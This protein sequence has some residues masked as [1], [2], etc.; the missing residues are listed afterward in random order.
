M[1]LPSTMIP[2]ATTTLTTA[3]ATVTFS[4]IPQTYTDLVMVGSLQGSRTTYG[5]DLNTQFNGDTG[6]NY[7]YTYMQGNGSTAFS[8]RYA[9]QNN[10]N[11]AGSIGG[12]GSGEYSVSTIHIMNYANTTTYKTAM[13]RNSHATQQ[14]QA[15]VGL[16]RS[17]AAVTSIAFTG[18]GYNFNAG[19]TFTLYGVKS[20]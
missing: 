19:S 20:A 13:A 1:P 7:S 4:S 12:N 2:I 11:F 3:S 6:T 5:A 8:N 14:T 17:T 15:F 16:W 10:M 18:N 9:S